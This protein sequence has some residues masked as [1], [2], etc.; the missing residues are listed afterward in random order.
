MFSA[1]LPVFL[2]L[3]VAALVAN[4]V[5]PAV[6][7]VFECL[8]RYM[9]LLKQIDRLFPKVREATSAEIVGFFSAAE[10][11]EMQGLTCQAHNYST[12]V[13]GLG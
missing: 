11:G 3:G 10:Q 6:V 12:A 9:Y 2:M 8:G 7:L 4:D 13:L 1:Y 5:S